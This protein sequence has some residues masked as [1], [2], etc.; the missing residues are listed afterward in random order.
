[1][2][3]ISFCRLLKYVIKLNLQSLKKKITI[4]NINN[5]E[6]IVEKSLKNVF[7]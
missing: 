1:M 7:N 6:I 4:K 5:E 3:N 2:K